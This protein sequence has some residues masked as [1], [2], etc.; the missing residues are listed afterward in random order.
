MSST[1]IVSAIDKAKLK[2]RYKEKAQ[3][4]YALAFLYACERFEYE[5]DNTEDKGTVI[6]ESRGPG[7]DKRYSEILKNFLSMG[8]KYKLIRRIEKS[9]FKVPTYN[10]PLQISDF[11]CYAVHKYLNK[12]E[13]DLFNKIKGKFRSRN[14]NYRGYGLTIFPKN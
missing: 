1:F 5:L 4:P 8:T 13:E 3:D 14:E 11:I 10:S 12:N 2:E 6:L 9:I 7:L